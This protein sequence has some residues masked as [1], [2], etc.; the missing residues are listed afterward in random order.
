MAVLWYYLFAFGEKRVE[1]EGLGMG[2]G[3]RKERKGFW[4]VEEYST[5]CVRLEVEGIFL[6]NNYKFETM[7]L[8][9]QH[10]KLFS[11][12]TIRVQRTRFCHLKM[13]LEID[14]EKLEFEN[15]VS[16]TQ[17]PS[18]FSNGKIKSSGLELLETKI[19]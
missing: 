6:K 4:R 13:H 19:V 16:H 14:C 2:I 3:D 17:F 8:V 7:L 15:R 11:F 5:V 18:A 1:R 12:L 9:R 10:F